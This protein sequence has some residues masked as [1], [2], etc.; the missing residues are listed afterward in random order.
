M[1]SLHP[2]AAAGSWFTQ[3]AMVPTGSGAFTSTGFAGYDQ[4]LSD[5][6]LFGSSFG[7]T[8]GNLQFERSGGTAYS[9]APQWNA[10]LRRNGNNGSY[11]MGEVGYSH[12][13]LSLARPIELG[14]T[15]RIARSERTVDVTSAHV[16]SGRRFRVGGGHLTPFAALGYAALNSAAFSEQGS[17]GFELVAQ[18]SLHQRVSS[19]FGLRY[20]RSWSW[21]ANQRLRLNLGAGYQHLLVA[22]DDLRAAFAGTPGVEFELGGLPRE[23]DSPWLEMN[24][25][26]SINDRCSWLF[27]YANRASEQALSVGMELELR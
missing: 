1:G 24:L 8:Q 17:T 19:D 2:G 4:W 13:Q 3:L 10:Y 26:G 9:Q 21:P 11:L 7:W 6:L 18:A 23:N 22:S 27:N 12:Q 20:D 25:V 16:E 15:R 14:T 5:D